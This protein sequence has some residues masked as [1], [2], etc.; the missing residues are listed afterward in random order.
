MVNYL[1]LLTLY[2]LFLFSLLFVL[3]NNSSLV[4][5]YNLAPFV[6]VPIELSLSIDKFSV[7]FCLMVSMISSVVMIYSYF[8]M[9]GDKMVDKFFFTMFFFI[10]SMFVLC[11]G[12]NMFWI[13][14][15]WDC[16]GVSSFLLVLFYQS[17]NSMNSGLVTFLMNRMGDLFMICS[18]C[19]V[20]DSMTMSVFISLSS[21]YMLLAASMTKSAQ[22]PFSC[23]LPMAMAAPTPVSSLVHSSTLVT[24]GA[25][26]LIRFSP[27]LGKGS[28][29]ISF[30]GWVTVVM[31][32]LSAMA[33][34][35]LKKIV[36][37]STMSHMGLVFMFIGLKDLESAM[38]HLIMHAIFKSSL[39]MSSGALIHD[40]MDNQDIRLIKI[41]SSNITIIYLMV[42]PVLSMAGI[43]FL[44]GFYSKEFMFMS[45][46]QWN[47]KLVMFI[48][49]L[50]SVCLTC[51][52][53][54]RLVLSLISNSTCSGMVVSKSFQKTR[55]AE[56]CYLGAVLSTVMGVFMSC[57][58]TS[59]WQYMVSFYASDQM[60]LII[61]FMWLGGVVGLVN[62][63]GNL[64][65]HGCFYS[66]AVAYFMQASFFK[67]CMNLNYSVDIK[68]WI[69]F[70]LNHILAKL[71]TLKE[72][73][74]SS[75]SSKFMLLYVIGSVFFIIT[76]L[77]L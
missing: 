15:G 66:S 35:N 77:M 21:F 57:S 52:Y 32:S 37:M 67:T 62:L 26:L 5:H 53:S 71:L 76:A 69:D 40:S 14:V 60:M 42:I 36:A 48:M 16:L 65:F 45:L 72:K 64:T 22:A 73:V 17:A 43:P 33:E 44:S 30:F 4:I 1:Y 3:D 46:G 7:C 29:L 59:S 49:F 25:F 19:L 34:F 8:Y 12:A 38:V 11:T 10:L 24:A 31:A 75:T 39:F 20:V 41:T 51:G 50:I 18:L 13:M 23:W 61:A 70:S 58:L 54:T 6:E 9:Y 63:S 47:R 2:S 55:L 56:V 68:G 74:L 28:D 27:S